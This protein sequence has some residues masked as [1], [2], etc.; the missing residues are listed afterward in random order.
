MAFLFS[1]FNITFFY[2]FSTNPHYLVH[3]VAR[4]MENLLY[5]EELDLDS[6]Q[7]VGWLW[8]F[9]FLNYTKW[10]NNNGEV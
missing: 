3:S 9:N 1:F 2:I 7:T 6:D 5:M 8:P 4:V 10:N